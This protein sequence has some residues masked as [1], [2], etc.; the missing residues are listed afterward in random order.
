MTVSPHR[1]PAATPALRARVLEALYAG[2][3]LRAAAGLAGL[4]VNVVQYWQRQDAGFDYE[5]RVA[6]QGG[7]DEIESEM[8]QRA[9]QGRNAQMLMALIWLRRTRQPKDI[10]KPADAT[11][12]VAKA[13]R[14]NAKGGSKPG[15]TQNWQGRR[16]VYRVKSRESYAAFLAAVASGMRVRAA[17]RA[18]GVTVQC[19][20]AW[21]Y[22][23]PAFAAAWAVAYE[24]AGLTAVDRRPAHMTRKP[25]TPEHKRRPR[26][27]I[28]SR[29]SEQ[30]DGD[31]VH[32]LKKRWEER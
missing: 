15:R 22:A 3:P 32:L 20:Y 11:P 18:I 10:A 6:M 14:G 28:A 4:S 29:P 16:A 23:D 25:R 30:S 21:R 27:P 31:L 8:H 26:G 19:V 17:A 9:R 12:A 13:P 5:C 7:A 1:W 24:H 2:A